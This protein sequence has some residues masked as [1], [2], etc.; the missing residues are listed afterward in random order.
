V[1]W[2][3][4]RRFYLGFSLAMLAAVLLGFSRTFFLRSWFPDWTDAHGAPEPFFYFHGVVFS[5]WFVLLVA[6]PS[7]VAAGRVDLHRRLGKFGAGLAVVMLVLGV[8]AALLAAARPTGFMDMPLPPLQFLMVPLVV[9][10]LFGVFVSLALVRRRNVQSHKRYMLLAS[11]SLVDAAVARWPFSV[12]AAECPV[13][14]FTTVDV[15]VDLFLV[16]MVAWDLA[17]RRRLHPVTLWG[18]LALVASQ[19]LR[20]TLSDTDAWLAFAARAVSLL[21]R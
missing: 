15:F 6:Q 10:S 2:S 11:I 7:L 21:G 14:G 9:I 13:P 8:M 19:P 12:M 3:A 1:R 5:A 16:P 4:E 18:G 20:H 17:S